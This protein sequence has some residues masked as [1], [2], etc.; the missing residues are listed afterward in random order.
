MDAQAFDALVIGAGIAG[1]ST[2][3][4]LAADRRV[5]LIEAEEAAGYHSTG[6]SAAIWIQNYGPPDVRALTGL[7]RAFFEQPPPGFVETPILSPRPVLF[8]APPEQAG[9][10]NG[11]LSEGI[12]LQECALDEVSAVIPALRPDYAVAAA[13][14]RDAFD[15][16]V[17]TLHQGFLRQLRARGGALALRSRAGLIERRGSV[18]GGADVERRRLHGARHRQLRGRL[19]RRR[20]R[21]GRRG[22]SRAGAEAPHGCHHRPAA[23]G[24]RALAHG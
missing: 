15:M 21:A 12:G 7:S 6:R 18:W 19:G 14:E 22:A 16:D 1:A 3:A 2:A 4:H 13:I 23:L 8:L 10:L 9:H 5:A 24:R 11:L 20:G 17:A